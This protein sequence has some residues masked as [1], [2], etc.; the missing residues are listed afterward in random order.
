MNKWEMFES[1]TQK[2]KLESIGCLGCIALIIVIVALLV[3]YFAAE[4]WLWSAIAVAV[5]GLP[6][7][8]F[9]QMI[10]LNILLWM[11]LPGR[12][13]KVSKE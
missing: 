13:V 2:A 4:V 5:F 12:I 9:W 1:E 6:A 7:L 10:G 8:S 3:I 11:L